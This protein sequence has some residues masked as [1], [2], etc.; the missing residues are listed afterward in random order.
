MTDQLTPPLQTHDSLAEPS[1]PVVDATAVE[2]EC[3]VLGYQRSL[4]QRVAERVSHGIDGKSHAALASVLD[5]LADLEPGANPQ[6]PRNLEVAV[7]A[8][9][10]DPP[11]VELASRIVRD[12]HHLLGIR[13]R[14]AR[15]KYS[16]AVLIVMGLGTLVYGLSPLAFVA[17]N[18]LQP[19]LEVKLVMGVPLY[20]ILIIAFAGA[21]GSSVSILVRIAEFSRLA[22]TD[23]YVLFLIGFFKPVIGMSFALFVFAVFQAEIIPIALDDESARNFF[24]LALAFLAG[25]SERFARDVVRRAEDV[26]GGR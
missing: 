11:D 6:I 7:T 22:N 9:E 21:L 26:V 13:R 2:L 24:I 3:D 15:Q 4:S 19:M 17:F 14:R 18:L 16:P 1:I 10:R 12:C 20:F 8:L 23:P 5:T 25:F